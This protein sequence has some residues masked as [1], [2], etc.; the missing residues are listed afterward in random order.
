MQTNIKVTNVSEPTIDRLS[1][2]EQNTFYVSL[3]SQVLKLIA[4]KK[5]QPTTDFKGGEK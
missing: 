5:E 2:S 1:E 4:E 3:L